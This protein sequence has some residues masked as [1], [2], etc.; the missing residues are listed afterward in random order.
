MTDTRTEPETASRATSRPAL[1]KPRVLVAAVI[2]AVLLGALGYTGL[3]LRS[4]VA[5]ESARAAAQ[6]AARRYAADLS[7]YDYRRLDSNFAAVTANAHGQF[8]QQYE[9]VSSSLTE[10]IRQNQAIS[11]GKVLTTATV[12][13]DENHAVVA[14]FVD[15]E[16]TNKNTPEPRVDRNRMQMTLIHDDGR[17]LID[18]IQLL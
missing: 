15:Q 12:S 7:T 13:A 11:E 10:L 4:H 6:E 14:L 5:A 9:Q 8:A 2:A 18:N 17:W 16:I 3:Q 1:R